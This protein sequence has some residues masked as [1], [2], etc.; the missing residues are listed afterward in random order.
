MALV[1]R[2]QAGHRHV[3]MP[4]P[5]CEQE[6]LQLKL[7]PLRSPHQPAELQ[8]MLCRGSLLNTHSVLGLVAG[9]PCVCGNM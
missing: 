7:L 3:S 6:P 9:N 8:Q 5:A 1:Q 2:G 4:L